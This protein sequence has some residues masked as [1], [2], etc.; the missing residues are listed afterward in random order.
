MNVL[1][2]LARSKL[3][4]GALAVNRDLFFLLLVAYVLLLFLR[5]FVGGVFA[6]INLDYPLLIVLVSGSM[7]VIFGRRWIRRRFIFLKRGL[8]ALRERRVVKAA[9]DLNRE[10]FS[11][12]L[13]TFLLLLL[14][15]TIWRGV[16][17]AHL[18]MN[19]L[20]IIVIISGAIAVLATKEE[21]P[22]PRPPTRWDYTFALLAGVA[23]TV[24][25]WYTTQTIGVLSYLIS[26]VGGALII[27]LSILLL[28][29]EE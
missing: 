1:G 5:T 4:K 8:Q 25:I 12:L 13:V 29:G 14:V 22:M 18:N 20:L 6:R 24:I 16:V 10:L 2:K 7:A 17:S 28:K 21:I 15:E 11:T 23:G 26:G 19:Y 3:V 27:L 9:L